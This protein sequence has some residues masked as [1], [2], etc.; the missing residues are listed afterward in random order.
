MMM[1]GTSSSTG[2]HE[3]CDFDNGTI[4]VNGAGIGSYTIRNSVMTI[5][6]NAN[7]YVSVFELNE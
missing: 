6:F 1:V 2:S 4:G 7:H 3:I 5:S